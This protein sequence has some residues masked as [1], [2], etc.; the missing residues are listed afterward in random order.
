LSKANVGTASTPVYVSAAACGV[1][2]LSATQTAN[3]GSNVKL[4]SVFT[5]YAGDTNFPAQTSSPYFITSVLQSGT[6]LSLTPDAATVMA[7][8]PMTFTAT[9]TA[10]SPG[11]TA[12]TGPTNTV[13]FTF[14][15]ATNVVQEGTTPAPGTLPCTSQPVSITKGVV[16]ATCTVIFQHSIAPTQGPVSVSATYS[17]DPNFKASSTS[18]P[19]AETVQDFSESLTVTPG[20]TAVIV[21]K[22]CTSV[23]G[24]TNPNCSIDLGQGFANVSGDAQVADPLNPATIALTLSG[25]NGFTDPLNVACTVNAVNVP[26]ATPASPTVLPLCLPSTSQLT[27]PAYASSTPLTFQIVALPSATV[28]QYLITIAVSD[29]SVSALSGNT[30]S[31]AINTYILSVSGPL[32]LA[33]GASGTTQA[34][35]NTASAA[36]GTSLGSKITC[37]VFTADGVPVTTFTAACTTPSSITVTGAATDAPISISFQPTASAAVA[38]P[39]I[40]MYAAALATPFFAMI[41]WLGTKK[42]PRRNFFRFLGMF[43]VIVGM[44]SLNGCGGNFTGPNI[45][46]KTPIP[47]GA[48]YIEAVANDSSGN[49]YYSV[50]PVDITAE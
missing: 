40:R 12:P 25:T 4:Y 13:Q 48:Y 26:Q 45:S 44:A 50:I 6:S 23:I 3:N 33:S 42:S 29:K 31:F 7:S 37:S 18:S 35:F 9:L 27:A 5:T 22:P 19:I 32:N 28:G 15:P 20:T 21:T 24:P 17:G 39:S 2:F 38:H 10:V 46:V 11:A 34:I 8:Q 16:T 49:P 41:V 43:L 47:P 36:T 14:S 30:T 1:T